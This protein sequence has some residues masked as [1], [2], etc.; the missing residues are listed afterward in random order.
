MAVAPD[1]N[2]TGN[3]P[4][5]WEDALLTTLEAPHTSQN[6]QFLNAWAHRE[7]ANFSAT[8]SGPHDIYANN[9]FFTTAGG[10]G[11]AT[12]F[13]PGTYPTINSHGVAGY[14]SIDIG[15]IATS[16]TLQQS[17]YDT[18]L[19]GIRSGNPS[20]YANDQ[21]F[22]KGLLKWSGS[23]YTGLDVSSAAS[24]PLGPNTAVG[25]GAWKPFQ[26]SLQ[27]EVVDK[28][29]SLLKNIPILNIPY[30]AGKKTA[31]KTADVVDTTGKF[32]S[33]V[34]SYRFFE[35]VGGGLLVL[36]GV[37][38][39]MRSVGAPVPGVMNKLAPEKFTESLESSQTYGPEG[40]RHQSYTRTEK[41][42]K[43]T[44]RVSSGSVRQ[45]K[46][47]PITITKTKTNARRK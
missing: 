29:D 9:P 34:T 22:Q 19:K 12:D 37:V 41:G 27:S 32:L 13:K 33:F 21:D 46:A 25:G 6:Y 26:P 23:S 45:T 39:L 16:E 5:N 35:I 11:S 31:N 40:V 20:A 38:G 7:Q 28:I 1:P 4:I 8:A 10:G 36:I 43:G 44:R 42:S 24:V 47:G 17:D 14:P 2:A 3:N 18:L 30:N 15:I